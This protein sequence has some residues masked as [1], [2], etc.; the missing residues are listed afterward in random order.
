MGKKLRIGVL[1]LQRGNTYVKTIKAGGF[2][3]AR[4]T[5]LCDFNVER[6]KHAAENCP[7]GR[8]APKLFTD[9]DEFF[10]SGLFDAVILCNYFNE[11][12]DFAVKAMEKGIHVLSETMAAPTMADCVRLCRAAEKKKAVYMLAENYPYTKTNMEMKRLYDEGT[13]GKLIFGEGEYVHMMSPDDVKKY[14]SPE[15]VG[16]NHWRRWMPVT[17]YSSH[18]LAPLMYVTGEMPKRVVAMAA[19]DTPEHLKEGTGRVRPEAAGVMLVTTDKDAVLRVNGSSYMAPRSNWFRIACSRGGAETVR[20][21]GSTDL[22]VG[23]NSWEVPEGRKSDYTYS[24]DWPENAAVC[25]SCGHSGGD[26]WTV[27]FFIDACFGRRKPFPDVYE[28]CAMSAV[29]ILGWRSICNGN[30]AY[31]IPDFRDENVR[32]LWQDDRL[33]PFQPYKNI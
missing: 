14:L 19:M 6:M 18:A 2:A 5:A 16:P 23:Y 4:V 32:V 28:S 15:A 10:N 3:D 26:Y 13:L 20:G 12:T 24:P 17:Y 33:N 7:T 9:A 25:D 11:H 30:M 1:G 31:D 22:R 29:A 8:Y 27:K 21:K